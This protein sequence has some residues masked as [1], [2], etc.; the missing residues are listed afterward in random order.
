MMGEKEFFSRMK[1]VNQYL[2]MGERSLVW[3]LTKQLTKER[4]REEDAE[5][6]S[7]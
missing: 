1:K 2:T 7:L 3:E 6:L 4:W 5:F